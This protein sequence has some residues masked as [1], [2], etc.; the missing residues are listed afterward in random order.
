MNGSERS[1]ALQD[2]ESELVS[3]VLIAVS[4]LLVNE[5]LNYMQS[6]M[7]VLERSK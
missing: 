3:P 5:G 2:P 4:V 6:F 7:Q 1:I